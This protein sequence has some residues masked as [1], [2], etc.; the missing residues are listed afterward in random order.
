MTLCDIMTNLCT[1]WDSHTPFGVSTC[2]NFDPCFSFCRAS[3]FS[4]SADNN[5]IV[6]Q[7]LPH[8]VAQFW[9]YKPCLAISG[10]PPPCTTSCIWSCDMHRKLSRTESGSSCH[11]SF[12][13]SHLVR[14]KS[15]RCVHIRKVVGANLGAVRFVRK[16]IFPFVRV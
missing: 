11:E 16:R 14:A 1:A 15:V 10:S 3:R 7:Y 9:H 2:T 4:A 8:S 6:D 13:L 5:K 12:E